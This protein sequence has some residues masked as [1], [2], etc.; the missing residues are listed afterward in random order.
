MMPMPLRYDAGAPR[1][2]L[3]Y[4]TP[5]CRSLRHCYAAR[6]RHKIFA[7]IAPIFGITLSPPLRF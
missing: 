7:V 6:Q 2:M 3:Y 5:F 1:L 4:A